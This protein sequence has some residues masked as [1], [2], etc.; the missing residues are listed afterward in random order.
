MSRLAEAV[1]N[2][3][4]AQLQA[5][6]IHGHLSSSEP[7]AKESYILNDDAIPSCVSSTA[8]DSIVYVGRAIGTV[9]AL[10]WHR[11]IPSFISLG[12]ARL[13]DTVLPQDQHAFEDLISQIRAD[14]SEWLWA[15][16]LTMPDVEDA[17]DSL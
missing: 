15:N 2:I 4:R 8:R 13:I 16:V 5:F 7:L 12:H 1:Q 14:I 9:K 11:Q 10:K 17:V 6:I 3:W